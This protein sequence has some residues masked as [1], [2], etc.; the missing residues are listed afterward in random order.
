M[1]SLAHRQLADL[2]AENL[3][4]DCGWVPTH[5]GS[6]SYPAGLLG[7]ISRHL[8]VTSEIGPDVAGSGQACIDDKE[9]SIK[10]SSSRGETRAMFTF[11][12]ELAHIAVAHYEAMSSILPALDGRD[13]ERFCDRVAAALVLPKGWLERTVD[14]PPTIE[15]IHSISRKSMVSELA[16]VSRL[17]DLGFACALLKMRKLA[18]GRWIV[19]S[20][21]GLPHELRRL[22]QPASC[23]ERQLDALDQDVVRSGVI[24]FG[25]ADGT[26]NAQVSMCRVRDGAHLLIDRLGYRERWTDD[27]LNWE[28]RAGKRNVGVIRVQTRQPWESVPIVMAVQMTEPG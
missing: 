11:A 23:L 27:F 25:V 13:L 9:R 28:L 26:C 6:M 16:V 14:A 10:V 17:R 15:Q 3:V 22:L 8:G 19:V 24:E 2:I 7:K 1:S 18:N 5:E 21:A 12:H 4:A 20:C